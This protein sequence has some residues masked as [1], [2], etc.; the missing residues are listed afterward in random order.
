MSNIKLKSSLYLI[1]VSSLI[2]CYALARFSNLDLTVAKEFLGLIPKIVTYEL[3]IIGIFVKWGWKSRFFRNWLVPFPNLSGT[4]IGNIH[5]DWVNPETGDRVPPIPVMLTITQSFFMCNC[6]MHTGEMKSYSYSEGFN[7]DRDQ[8][9][10]Q[11][12]YLYS[13]KPRICLRDRSVP[14]DGAIVFDIIEK[15]VE[16]MIGRYWTER[17]TTGEIILSR[18]SKQV[19]EEFPIDFGLHPVTEPEKVH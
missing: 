6:V 16:K 4:W 2:I 11:V 18:Y 7:N 12:S 5:S 13:S 10:N 8:Q 14:H 15:P 19:I 1:V 17:K 3:F 9:I